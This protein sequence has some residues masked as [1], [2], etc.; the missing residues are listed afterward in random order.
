MDTIFLGSKQVVYKASE[1]WG[2]LPNSQLLSLRGA[3]WSSHVCTSDM[4]P[5][6]KLTRQGLDIG[7]NLFPKI[8]NENK[9]VSL[10]SSLE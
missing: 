9:P 8:W 7:S 1:L 6:P 4:V 3:P 5:G 2:Y 10:G